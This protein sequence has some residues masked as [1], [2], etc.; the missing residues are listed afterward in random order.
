[1]LEFSTLFTTCHNPRFLLNFWN[2]YWICLSTQNNTVWQLN[3]SIGHLPRHKRAIKSKLSTR[4]M[5]DCETTKFR[6]S[7]H[8][9]HSS[10]ILRSYLKARSFNISLTCRQLLPVLG[11]HTLKVVLKPPFRHQL[12]DYLVSDSTNEWEQTS[13]R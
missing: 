12:D 11:G 1:M 5:Y 13:R 6:H 7:H 3:H 2:N 9:H 10:D 4:N 8:S